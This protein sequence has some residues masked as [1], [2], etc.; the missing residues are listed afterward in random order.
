MKNRIIKKLILWI[1]LFGWMAIIFLFSN[2]NENTSESMSNGVLT[3]IMRFFSL[4]IDSYLLRK[5]AHFFEY[6]ILGILIILVIREYKKVTR[7]QIILGI[8]FCMLYACSDELHQ[9][10]IAGRS[11][12]V[13]DVMIDTFGSMSGIFFFY[14][15]IF[16][17][18]KE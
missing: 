3:F 12:H 5:I 18:G 9:M 1:L 16:P 11:P 10:F 17:Y 6:M 7:K 2:Q 8:L 4:E 14:F 13:F 15:L